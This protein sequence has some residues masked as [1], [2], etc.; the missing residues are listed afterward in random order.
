M[1]NKYV[2]KCSTFVG[3]MQVTTTMTGHFTP[4]KWLPPKRPTAKATRGAARILT[5]CW[6]ECKW[7]K[8][9]GNVCP[10]FIKL[11]I[12]WAAPFLDINP[13][14]YK[15]ACSKYS[16]RFIHN[17]QNWENPKASKQK[18]DSINCGQLIPWNSKIKR[19]ELLVD[20]TTW[21]RLPEGVKEAGYKQVHTLWFH[22]YED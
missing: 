20:G 6:S 5:L 16:K 13:N 19:D 11:T 9:L 18:N 4:P 3:E 7:Y 15:K 14:I 1:A 12:H 17:G 10:F 21:I 8:T 2:K 22:L